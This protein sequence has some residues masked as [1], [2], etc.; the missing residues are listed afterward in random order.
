MKYTIIGSL[1]HVGKLLTEKLKAAGHD[2]TVIS[3]NPENAPRIEA[4][5]A[6]AAIGSIDDYAFLVQT[7]TGHDGVFTMVPPKLDAPDW[8]EYI[9]QVG[10]IYKDAILEA[11]IKKV[12]NLSSVGAHLPEGCGPVSGLYSVENEL[13]KLQQTDVL[14]LRPGFFYDNFLGNIGMIKQA[15]VIGGNYGDIIMVLSDPSDIAA[16]A[17]EELDK[18]AF[19][20]K[21]VR[22][23]ASDERTTDDVAG[24]L[25]KA[26]GKPDL[27]WVAFSDEDALNGMLTGGFSGDVAANYVE[28]GKSLA[29]GTMLEDYFKNKPGLAGMKLEGFAGEFKEVY[30]KD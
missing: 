19:T 23:I 28:M 13:N 2:V 5:G 3:S 6:K 29:N 20:G 12:V 4:L 15:G 8:K 21:S 16:A 25:G 17:A 22:Y 10:I 30:G 26:I 27:R 18:L 7:F 24:V 14:H 1:G 9:H 11:G